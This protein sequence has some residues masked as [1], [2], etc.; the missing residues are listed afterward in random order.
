[1]CKWFVTFATFFSSFFCFH[2][3]QFPLFWC[4]VDPAIFRQYAARFSSWGP[5]GD[6]SLSTSVWGDFALPDVLGLDSDITITAWIYGLSISDNTHAIF[7]YTDTFTTTSDLYFGADFS[8]GLFSLARKAVFPPFSLIYLL[9]Q[10]VAG[11]STDIRNYSV[12]AT[13]PNLLKPRVCDFL[14]CFLLLS[15]DCFIILLALVPRG[16]D[17]GSF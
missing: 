1:L 14:L 2:S 17:I 6:S 4:S 13:P 12:S 7:H 10:L 8:T 5:I 11:S 9:G 16:Y 15:Q 3:I